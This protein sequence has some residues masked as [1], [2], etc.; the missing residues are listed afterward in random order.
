MLLRRTSLDCSHLVHY[1]YGRVGLHYRYMDSGKLYAGGPG[2]KR[3]AE[4]RSGD[5]VV[6]RGHVGIVADPERR[7]FLSALRTGVEITS[8][9]S[10]YWKS[11]GEARFLRYESAAD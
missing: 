7:T 8:Y 11:R 2:F 10:H 4:P 1:L 6:W 9:D 3:V 5:L